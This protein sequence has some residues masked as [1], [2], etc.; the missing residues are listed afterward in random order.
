MTRRMWIDLKRIDWKIFSR[1]ICLIY[2]ILHDIIF[3][4]KIRITERRK[5]DQGHFYQMSFVIRDEREY[6]GW[7]TI[8]FGM[9]K[10][11]AL[12]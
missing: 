7:I 12:G 1:L 9:I 2:D 8:Y 4:W 5:K 6:F 3:I 10:T 11:D